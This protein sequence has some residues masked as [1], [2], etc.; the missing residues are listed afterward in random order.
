M[1]KK[2]E[3]NIHQEG[4]HSFR[5]RMMV[6][7]HRLDKVL[8]ILSEARVYRDSHKLS[9][10][11]DV[12]ESAVIESRIKKQAIKGLS[13]GDALDRYLLEVTPTKKGASA[14]EFRIGKAKRALLSMKPLHGVTPDDVLAFLDE[15]G[16]SENNKRKYASIISHLYRTAIRKWRLPV[17]NPVSGQIDLPSNG[18]PRER[19]LHKGEYEALMKALSGEAK[20]FVIVAVETAMRRS[21]IFNLCREN[22]NKKSCSAV[23][24]DTK[25]GETRTTLF[26]SAAMKALQGLNLDWKS[27]GEVWTISDSQLRRAWEKA[28]ADIDAADLHF[29][30]LR[31]EGT[32][33]L[34]ER[35]L[36]V[37]EVQSITGHKTLSELRKYTHLEPKNILSKLG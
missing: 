25:N 21:E 2:I 35:G 34:F 32:S 5:V 6:N 27:K 23:L 17:T 15:I 22:I 12:H 33:R 4:P 26:S 36:N 19:R 30:D 37:F 31:H 7:G 13:V 28:R 9:Q 1:R 20:A 16:G 18:K 8:D 29:H 14:E 10:A 3:K 11:L 24:R